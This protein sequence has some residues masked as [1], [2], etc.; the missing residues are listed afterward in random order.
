MH[1]CLSPTTRLPS[2]SAAHALPTFEDTPTHANAT[3][4]GPYLPDLQRFCRVADRHM[5]TTLTDGTTVT[6]LRDVTGRIVGLRMTCGAN[7]AHH[8]PVHVLGG[9]PARSAQQCRQP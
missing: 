9:R 1:A 7:R 5:S 3:N 6:H 4:R 8:D 2:Q